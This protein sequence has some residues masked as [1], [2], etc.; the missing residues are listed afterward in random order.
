MTNDYRLLGQL[1][2]KRREAIGLTQDNLADKA[3]IS[4][5]TVSKLE[6]GVIKDPSIFTIASLAE[7]MGCTID[8]LLGPKPSQS[9]KA[10]TKGSDTFLLCDMNGVLVRFFQRAFVQ[11]AKD[12]HILLDKVET[13]FW[14]YNDMA[15]RG[16]ISTKEFNKVM[17]DRLGI[18]KFDWHK[19]YLSAIEP[20][21]EMHDC[22][23]EVAKTNRV[24]ILS[25]IHKGLIPKMLERNLIPNIDYSCIVDSSEVHKI[26]PDPKVYQLTE[27]LVGASGKEILFVDDS[28]TNLMAAERFNWRVMWF[29]DYRP[30]DS[31]ARVK[32]ALGVDF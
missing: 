6:R 16:E 15:N 25:N 12:N 24:G 31:V 11:I 17:A 19:S 9:S 28:R 18:T 3:G 13:T 1:I 5:S 22:V 8:N 20:I 26:K 30:A 21:A 14:H 23:R 7:V 10:K 29:D 2:Q 27:R 32:N 4:Y